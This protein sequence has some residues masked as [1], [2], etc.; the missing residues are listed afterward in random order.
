[1]QIFSI[2]DNKAKYFQKPFF[3][4]CAGEAIRGFSSAVN[5]KKEGN[6]LSSF[7]A[8]FSLHDVG[9]FDISTGKITATDPRLILSGNDVSQV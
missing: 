4:S 6:P 8:D 2:R 1:M 3:M 7:P 9:Y 5:D